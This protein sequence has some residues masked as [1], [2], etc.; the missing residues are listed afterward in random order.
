M[1]T[2]SNFR[3]I[4]GAEDSLLVLSLWTSDRCVDVRRCGKV[5]WYLVEIPPNAVLDRSI[6]VCLFKGLNLGRAGAVVVNTCLLTPTSDL[7]GG[8][9]TALCFLLLGP[10]TQRRGEGTGE[11][12]EWNMRT[13]LACLATATRL[14]SSNESASRTRC[15]RSDDRLDG[16]R[17]LTFLGRCSTVARAGTSDLFES[18]NVL[19]GL[20]RRRRKS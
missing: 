8:F 16:V 5:D 14:A 6:V 1:S 20:W 3:C 2:C 17:L 7:P 15:V 11:L 9:S 10:D 12:F 18:E 4:S 13:F 19:D